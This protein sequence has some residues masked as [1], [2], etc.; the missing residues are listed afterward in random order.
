MLSL[1]ES[2]PP[3]TLMWPM[4]I[5]VMHWIGEANYVFMCAFYYNYHVGG[6]FHGSKI[7]QIA[8]I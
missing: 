7:S 1:L 5:S 6:I 4:S 2:L 3:T 8:L